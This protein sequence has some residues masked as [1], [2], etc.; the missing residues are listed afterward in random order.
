ML[1]RIT[2]RK[3]KGGVMGIEP[4]VLGR[5]GLRAGRI[6]FAAAYG[7]PARAVEE[8]V[9]RGVTYL[10]WG[11]MR[12]SGMGEAIRNIIK[13][14][15]QKIQICL[16]TY[17][18]WR[19]FANRSIEKGLTALG[20]DYADVLLLGYHNKRPSDKI[21]DWAQS[22]KETGK[23][24]FLAISTHNRK[25]V[26]VLAA[27]HEID[28]FH[29]RYNAA[30]RGAEEDIFPH[31]SP[32][33]GP[34]IVAF[35]ATRWGQLLRPKRMPEGARI[36]TAADCYR[37]DLSHPGVHLVMAGPKTYEESQAIARALELGP[38]TDEELAWMRK[39]GDIVYGRE[40]ETCRC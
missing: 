21:M 36:P 8:A 26:P 24:R 3:H 28:I 2:I 1:K 35:T 27:Q 9:E 4:V 22:L 33:S 17:H 19:S 6:G 7:A 32:D 30:H 40:A 23:V 37:F 25:L 31:I 39:I 38:M 14:D 5:T 18:R 11:S 15:R 20:A 10:Y 13:K 34:G 12:R 29:V 16:Q